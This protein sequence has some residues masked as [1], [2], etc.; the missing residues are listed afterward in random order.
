MKGDPCCNEQCMFDRSGKTCQEADECSNAVTCNGMQSTCP[1]DSNSFKEDGRICNDG[2][3]TCSRGQCTGS[4]CVLGS[5]TECLCTDMMQLCD[6]CCM[7]N[8]VCS[9]T[10]DPGLMSRL[11]GPWSM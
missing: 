5:Y 7:V 3:N 9:S 6:V 1:V 4:V 8:G 10:F 2:N 11:V